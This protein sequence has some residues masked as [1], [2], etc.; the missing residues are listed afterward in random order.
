M[1]R[2]TTLPD[3][4]SSRVGGKVLLANDDFFAPKENLL[5]PEA[6]IYI[7][8]KYTDAGKWMDGW[9]TRRRRTPGHDWC[10]V[11]LGIAGVLRGVVVDTTH[12]KGNHPQ[13]C[14]LEACSAPH[15]TSAQELAES[16][17]W[18]GI[19][20]ESRLKGDLQNLFAVRD[21][22]RYTHLRFRIFP[23]GGVA[24][25]RVHGEPMFDWRALPAGEEVDLAS[26][27][28]GARVIACSDEFFSRPENLLMPGRGANMGDGWETRRRRGP[29]HDWVVI[30]LG[31]ASIVRRVEVDTAHFKGNFPESFSLDGSSVRSQASLG[32]A[33]WQRLLRRTPLNADSI[34]CGD[35]S[36]TGEITHVRFNIFPDGGVSRLRIVGVPS[37]AARATRALE[38]L[39]A[40]PDSEL[41]AALLS[42]CGSSSWVEKMLRARPYRAVKQFCAA[43]DRAWRSLK[44]K[45]WLEAFRHHPEIGARK[46]AMAQSQ[47]AERWSA[48]EQ[49]AASTSPAAVI[50]RL[51][52]AN[53]AYAQRFGF[54][55]LVDATGKSA[56]EMLQIAQTR[57]TKDRKAELRIAA[58]E[59][60]RIMLRRLEKLL[61]I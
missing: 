18:T 4:A 16:G 26:V 3:L 59:Q 60:R 17:E 12:F 35:V 27:L 56:E 58:E 36:A 13:A 7:P 54:I 23:D 21:P 10:I 44:E 46:A 47:Q 33:R 2:F 22:H 38:L 52:E 53:R 31:I 41:R 39:N 14:S 42:C 6:P 29:G 37:A 25:L 11:R 51:E 34:H 57:M 48:Q 24:R 20:P 49:S 5:R 15:K 45:D 30:Q 43:A 28:R 8:G 9:E 40:F 1:K 50:S 61:G 55:F 32:N 19:L